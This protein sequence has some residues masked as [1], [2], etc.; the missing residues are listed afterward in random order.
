[1]YIHRG[2]LG[3]DTVY[4]WGRTPTLESH[5]ASPLH[6]ED[7]DSMDLWNVGILLQ[8]YTALYLRRPRLKSSPWRW[9]QH[10]PPKRWYPTTT[11]HG[12]TTQ[13]IS[14]WIFIL[15]MEAACTSET[16]VSY[17]HLNLHT[18]DGGGM[19]LRNV[20]IL[21]QHYTVSQPRR[22]RLES[23]PWRWRRHGPPKRWYPTTTWIFTLKME[24]A[25][26]SETLVSHHVSRIAVAS[27]HD[28]VGKEEVC[29]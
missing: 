18:E 13:K 20:G 27:K 21:L 15:K 6:P 19:D 8:N 2:F 29:I 9:R 14:T 7:R 24:A 5:A 10:G 1:M 4:C 12:V 23:S 17:H 26:T 11:L 3:C 28:V 22:S 16:L 25:W